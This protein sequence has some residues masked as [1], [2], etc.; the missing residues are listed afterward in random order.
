MRRRRKQ[1]KRQYKII[2]FKA[3]TDTDADLLEWW[4]SIDAGDRSEAL[5]ELM[6]I[7]L[8][9]QPV[10]PRPEDSLVFIH[11]ELA[12]MRTALSDLPG[13]V[14][15]V[16]QHVSANGVVLP[17]ARAPTAAHNGHAINDQDALRREQRIKKAKW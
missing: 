14:E 13:Y 4:E 10:R 17:E 2:G 15:R 3:Y 7:G 12:W 6:R 8:G 5:R 9:Y 16:I 11:D 1:P